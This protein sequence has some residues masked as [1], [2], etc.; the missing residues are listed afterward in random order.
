MK[1]LIFFVTIKMLYL[2]KVTKKEKDPLEN[3][4]DKD[5]EKLMKEYGINKTSLTDVTSLSYKNQKQSDSQQNIVKNLTSSDNNDLQNFQLSK[6]NIY[7]LLT[8]LKEFNLFNRLP[9]TAKNIISDTFSKQ[10]FQNELKS[11]KNSNEDMTSLISNSLN[12]QSFMDHE[13]KL[14]RKGVLMLIENDTTSKPVW[15]IVNS[16]VFTLYNSSNYLNIIKLY[17]MALITLRDILYHPCFFIFYS[18]TALDFKSS[19]TLLCAA[20]FR[21]KALWVETLNNAR[22]LYTYNK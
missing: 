15:V 12:S 13:N 14:G 5:L 21:E 2:I 1:L 17:R 4:S 7:T 11:H 22:D 10:S 18:N 3:I 19:N 6:E 8:S 16:K 9:V 20:N